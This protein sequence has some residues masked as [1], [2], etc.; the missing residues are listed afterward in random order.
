MGATFSLARLNV[1]RKKTTRKTERENNTKK[2]RNHKK[3][4][5]IPNNQTIQKGT[6]SKRLGKHCIVD[7]PKTTI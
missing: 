6:I 2:N 4:H 5:N 7:P 3:L 1:D